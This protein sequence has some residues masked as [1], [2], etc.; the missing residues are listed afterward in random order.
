M[1][2]LR[3]LFGLTKPVRHDGDGSDARRAIWREIRKQGWRPDGDEVVSPPLVPLDTFFVGNFEEGSIAP[4]VSDIPLETFREILYGI[5]RRPDV[6]AVFCELNPEDDET[7]WPTCEAIHIY[8]EQP[9]DEVAEW[10]RMLKPD[11]VSRQKQ[12]SSGDG[13]SPTASQVVRAWWD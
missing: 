9:P 1:R 13:A 2:I 11:E 5:A 3:R 6:Q 4:N 8:T 12:Q 10:V 7:M